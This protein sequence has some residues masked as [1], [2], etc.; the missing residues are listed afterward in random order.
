MKQI[1]IVF[2]LTMVLVGMEIFATE[3]QPNGA[4]D[5]V[6]GNYENSN[7]SIQYG[8]G[9]GKATYSMPSEGNSMALLPYLITSPSTT[10]SGTSNLLLP[11]LLSS[12]TSKESYSGTTYHGRFYA[13]YLPNYFGLHFGMSNSVFDLKAKVDPIEQ[14]L[15]LLLLQSAAT[16][17]SSSSMSTAYL[18]YTIASPATSSAKIQDSITYFDIGP[19]FHARPRKTLDPYLALGV[20]AGSC[21]GRC[22]SYRGYA[23]LGFRINFGGGYIFL[24][25]EYSHANIRI[26]K[27]DAAEPLK[28]Q[29]GI[30]GFGLY[31]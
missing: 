13:E 1:R 30:F 4:N 19:T 11:A 27:D 20:G 6:S 2:C 26:G 18:L 31:L 10:S 15:P 9:A 8:F 25:G 21:A 16:S 7:W 23:K 24:E 3:N 17:S 28:N 12:S 14:L 5:R 29:I 22:Y